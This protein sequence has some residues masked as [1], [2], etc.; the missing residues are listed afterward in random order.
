MSWT[1]CSRSRSNKTDSLRPEG[2]PSP[3]GIHPS[4]TRPSKGSVVAPAALL[5]SGSVA[6]RTEPAFDPRSTQAAPC[7]VGVP[8]PGHVVPE[9]HTSPNRHTLTVQQDG[10]RLCYIAEGS[11][12]APV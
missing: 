12:D 6:A 11:A 5:A 1:T 8:P 2:G 10:R 7:G 9:L 3:S 4:M